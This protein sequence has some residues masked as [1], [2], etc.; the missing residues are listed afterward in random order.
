MRRGSLPDILARSALVAPG[1]VLSCYTFAQAV[2]GRTGP[3]FWEIILIL[4]PIGAAIVVQRPLRGLGM[5]QAI[6]VMAGLDP[7][8]GSSPP[9]PRRRWRTRAPAAAVAMG[10]GGALIALGSLAPWAYSDAPPQVMQQAAGHGA[11]WPAGGVWGVGLGAAILALAAFTYRG[12]AAAAAVA[13]VPAIV[14]VVG[15]PSDLALMTHRIHAAMGTTAATSDFGI[16]GIA[17]MLGGVLA[18]FGALVAVVR[19]RRTN[20]PA[21][22]LPPPPF[23]RRE[24]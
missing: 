1:L 7:D 11:A 8:G 22:L 23:R 19:S 12:R 5:E 16:G 3:W 15:S 10:A 21:V 17:A 24:P 13:L 9:P 6:R 18:L 20:A 2:E 4:G 14:Q